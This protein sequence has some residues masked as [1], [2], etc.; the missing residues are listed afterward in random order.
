MSE[1]SYSTFR[2][3]LVAVANESGLPATARNRICLSTSSFG[4]SRGLSTLTVVSITFA[5]LFPTRVA[6]G[7]L[8]PPILD[9]EPGGRPESYRSPWVLNSCAR[10]C[11]RIYAFTH[12]YKIFQRIARL[13]SHAS[14]PPPPPDHISLPPPLLEGAWERG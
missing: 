6:K 14:P 1:Y 11:F 3:C 10:Y 8:A 12:A 5:S 7:A 4:I 9:L 13:A 2:Q